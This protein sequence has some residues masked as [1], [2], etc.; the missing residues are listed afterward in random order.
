MRRRTTERIE[1][2]TISE[3]AERIGISVR[4]LRRRISEG[5]LPAYQIGPRLLRLRVDEVDAAFMSIPTVG[6]FR[7]P[8]T[9]KSR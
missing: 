6:N 7:S 9:D 4:T 3:A 8:R 2:E 5:A 1:Y